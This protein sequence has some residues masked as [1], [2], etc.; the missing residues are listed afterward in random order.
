M[1]KETTLAEVLAS[2]PEEQRI[3]LTLHY[4]RSMSSAEIA[5]LLSVPQR[6]VDAVISAGKA[7]LSGLLGL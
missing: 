1:S 2:L 3:I 5:A 6:S 7:R 4:L